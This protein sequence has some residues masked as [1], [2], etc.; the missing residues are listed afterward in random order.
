MSEPS[1][2]RLWRGHCHHQPF[3]LL[4]TSCRAP[5]RGSVPKDGQKSRSSLA[6]LRFSD[7]SSLVGLTVGRN[8]SIAN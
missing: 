1:N 8:S 2:A 4:I 5:M 6:L 3:L 7:A